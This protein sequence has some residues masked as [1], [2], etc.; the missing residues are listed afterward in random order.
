MFSCNERREFIELLVTN[1]FLFA[2]CLPLYKEF[3]AK[4]REWDKQEILYQTH[5]VSLDAQ[6]KLLSEKC[7]QF[8]VNCH[9]A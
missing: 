2:P 6:Q 7:N 1:S 4:S 5:L 9:C 3:R 8:Q